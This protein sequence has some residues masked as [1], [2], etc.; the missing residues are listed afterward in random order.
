MTVI[1]EPKSQP[2]KFVFRSNKA[3]LGSHS[4]IHRPDEQNN[5]NR[6][7]QQNMRRREA[8]THTIRPIAYGSSSQLPIFL[9]PMFINFHLNQACYPVP[10]PAQQLLSGKPVET[11]NAH[12]N[13]EK[14]TKLDNYSSALNIR[15]EIKTGNICNDVQLYLEKFLES[16]KND[17]DKSGTN[18]SNPLPLEQETSQ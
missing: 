12:I 9:K 7:L 17:L 2:T 3:E 16:L 10:K 15:K 11:E 8:L 5:Q 14:A 18:E 1:E 6:P 13:D 4:S